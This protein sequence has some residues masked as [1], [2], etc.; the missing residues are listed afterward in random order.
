MIYDAQANVTISLN[1]LMHDKFFA[2]LISNNVVLKLSFILSD[3]DKKH[4]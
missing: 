3:N 2:G 4:L 1:D